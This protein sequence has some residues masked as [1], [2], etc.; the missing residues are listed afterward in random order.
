[1]Y[2]LPK[3]IRNLLKTSIGQLARNDEQLLEIIKN[4]KYIVSIGDQVT[5]TLLKHGVKPVFC[6]IDYKTHRGNCEKEVVDLIKSFGKKTVVV[7]N[8]AGTISDDLWNIISFAYEVL[9][10][11]SLRVE[12]IGEEDLA[13]LAAIYFA[14]SDVTIIYGLPDKGVLVVKPTV[15][16][17][18]KVKEVLDKM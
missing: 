3:N 15:E 10:P 1:M 18:K 14:P 12:V 9:E 11:G 17:K 4:D 2:I 13:S 16:N 8:P 6:V 7:E 5:Y